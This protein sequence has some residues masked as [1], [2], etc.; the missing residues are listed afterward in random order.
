MF[1][2]QIFQ[3][4]LLELREATMLGVQAYKS[5][6]SFSVFWKIDKKSLSLVPIYSKNRKPRNLGQC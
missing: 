4:I 1:V 5:L 6:I 2:R 3:H